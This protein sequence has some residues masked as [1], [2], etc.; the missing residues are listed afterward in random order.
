MKSKSI[1]YY[2][3]NQLGEPIYSVVQKQLRSTA[4]DFYSASLY[5]VDFGSNEVITGKRGYLTMV[6]QIISC[7]ERSDSEYVFFCEHDVL[8]HPSHFEFT[9]SRDDIFYYNENVWR[10]EYGSDVAI[11]HDRMISLSSL[12][13]NRVFALKHYNKRLEYILGLNTN[14]VSG[15]PQWAR[16]MGYEPGTKKRKRGGFSDDDYET[17]LSEYPNIDIRHE[18]TFSSRKTSPDEFKHK[19]KWW[20]EISIKEIDG[21]DL[22]GLFNG[23]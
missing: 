1:I 18:G 8:Y 7:L 3:D 21:W 23:S 20:K 16:I 2:T 13:V 11:R 9:P 14:D 22:G 4:L 10:W 17:W 5:P 12:C 6:R 19:P 15:E